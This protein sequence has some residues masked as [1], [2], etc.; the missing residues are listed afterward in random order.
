MLNQ[1]LRIFDKFFCFLGGIAFGLACLYLTC[2]VL[3]FLHFL[4]RCILINWKNVVADEK[5]D[6]SD[7]WV[8]RVQV[9][10]GHHKYRFVKDGRWTVS[11]DKRIWADENGYL[12][13][14][15]LTS[16]QGVKWG[17]TCSKDKF[18]RGP[19]SGPIA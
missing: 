8:L 18:Q 17:E 6:D 4:Y 1:V 2:K 14:V 5:K 10:I 16:S 7:E 11:D 13:N 12:H 3:Y 15:L 19:I 9:T